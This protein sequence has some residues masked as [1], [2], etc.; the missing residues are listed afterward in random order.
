MV[1]IASLG[2]NLLA[3]ANHLAALFLG[4]ELNSQPMF[5]LIGNAFRQKR[6]L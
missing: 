4:I 5:G 1:L 3:N 2:G 6:S